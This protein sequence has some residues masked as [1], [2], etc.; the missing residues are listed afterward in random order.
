M[1]LLNDKRMYDAEIVINTVIKLDKDGNVENKEALKECP[2]CHTGTGRA[3]HWKTDEENGRSTIGFVCRL[4][5]KRWSLVYKNPFL[6][7]QI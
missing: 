4:C 6:F 2:R 3:F 1:N 7:I 5:A